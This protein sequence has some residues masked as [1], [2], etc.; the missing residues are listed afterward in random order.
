MRFERYT[1]LVNLYIPFARRVQPAQIPGWVDEVLNIAP[2]VEVG[3][4]LSLIRRV[5]VQ[6]SCP[7]E[8]PLSLLSSH[9]T[10]RDTQLSRS[11]RTRKKNHLSIGVRWSSPSSSELIS[12]VGLSLRPLSFTSRRVTLIARPL[13]TRSPK[14][15]VSS[16]DLRT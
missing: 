7:K 4:L 6:T 15:E 8:F 16:S 1:I 14:P 12:K 5:L 13:L 9:A 10:S 2:S 11:A 3:G